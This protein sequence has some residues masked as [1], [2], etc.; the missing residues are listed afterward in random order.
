MLARVVSKWLLFG[1]IWPGMQDRV[2]QDP[3][4]GAALVRRDDV[5]KPVS[6]RTTDSKR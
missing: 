6:S 2:K 5:R 1:T 4:R 3:L